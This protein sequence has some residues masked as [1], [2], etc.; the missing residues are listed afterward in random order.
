MKQAWQNHLSKC[1]KCQ[2]QNYCGTGKTLVVLAMC[3]EIGI[4]KTADI[5]E[6]E[7]ASVQACAD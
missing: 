1:G 4:D 7:I 2:S 3:V 6:N 5:I